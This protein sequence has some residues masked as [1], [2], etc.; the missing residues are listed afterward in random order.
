MKLYALAVAAHPDDV[1]LS[2]SG[3]IIKLTQK[4]YPVGIL[5]L[6]RGELGTRGNAKIREKEAKEAAVLMGVSVRE[7]LN[8]P[9]GGI[10]VTSFITAPMEKF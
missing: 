8:L 9:D 2:C 4:N 6:S 5:D 3:T 1:E 7:N 10:E